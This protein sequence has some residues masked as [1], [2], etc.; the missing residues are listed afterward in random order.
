MN[1]TYI[2]YTAAARGTPEPMERWL[3]DLLNKK[4][5][6]FFSEKKISGFLVGF[7]SEIVIGCTD[8]C[9]SDPAT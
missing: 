1:V 2:F 3:E 6:A 9:R 4:H 7:F 5:K 8:N